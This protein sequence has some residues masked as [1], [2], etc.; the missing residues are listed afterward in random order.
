MKAS[1][2][3]FPKPD[4]STNQSNIYVYVILCDLRE[5]SMT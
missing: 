5:M 2:I 4:I 1:F 3:A